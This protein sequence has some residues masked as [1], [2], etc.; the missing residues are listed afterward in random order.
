MILD[1]PNHAERQMFLKL[2]YQINKKLIPKKLHGDE[3]L[4]QSKIAI[5]FV[6]L[7]QNN[8]GFSHTSAP[9]MFQQDINC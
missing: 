9:R 7:N 1:H 4:S 5:F 2:N 6:F 3:I 8:T